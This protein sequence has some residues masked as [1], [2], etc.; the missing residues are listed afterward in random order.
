MAIATA[1]P[2]ALLETVATTPT[3]FWNDSC[4]AAELEDAISDG[5]TG[6][7]SNPVLVLDALRLEP[8]PWERRIRGVAAAMPTA[9]DAELAWRIAEEMAVRGATLLEPVFERTRRADEVGSR[10]RSTRPA[11]GTPR[12]CSSRRS[13]FHGSLRTSR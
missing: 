4:A 3:E 12:R 9:S 8:E 5:A 7:T 1:T 2:S 10:S 13:R 11:T 6:A